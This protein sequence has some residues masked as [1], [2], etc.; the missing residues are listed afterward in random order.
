MNDFVIVRADFKSYIDSVN[1]KYV[2]ENYADFDII[3]V[4]MED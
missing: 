3:K 1:S 4:H 2:Y